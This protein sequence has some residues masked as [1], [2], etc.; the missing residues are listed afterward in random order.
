MC[1][2]LLS[3]NNVWPNFEI[4]LK[5]CSSRYTLSIVFVLRFFFFATRYVYVQYWLNKK[6]VTFKGQGTF[7]IVSEG[8]LHSLSSRK[9]WNCYFFP[10]V[11]KFFSIC[12]LSELKWTWK[13]NN[14]TTTRLVLFTLRKA[15]GLLGY[16]ATI[17]SAS[18]KHMISKRRM[19]G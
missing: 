12:Q 2:H 17:T 13:I 10:P 16:Q 4:P 5:V 19:R 11:S 1:H 7:Y 15:V 3:G 18:I 8:S 9:Q 14:L 6:I